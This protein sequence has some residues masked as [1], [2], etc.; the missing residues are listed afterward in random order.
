[1]E[2][3]LP[4]AQVNWGQQSGKATP[5]GPLVSTGN[6]L[7]NRLSE[8]FQGFPICQIVSPLCWKTVALT[9]ACR[10]KRSEE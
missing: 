3:E 2:A 8:R 6:L 7:I 10:S 4:L 5:N 1:M 9:R